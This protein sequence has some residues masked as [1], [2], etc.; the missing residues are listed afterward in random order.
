MDEFGRTKQIIIIR[1]GPSILTKEVDRFIPNTIVKYD[2][3]MINE[4][5]KWISFMD[6]SDNR[7]YCCAINIDGEE[8][9]ELGVDYEDYNS[10]KVLTSYFDDK[11][12]YKNN[13]LYDGGL[14]YAEL[15][16]D[17]AKKDYSALGG[18]PYGQKLRIT[19]NGKSAIASKGDI[20]AGGRYHPKINIHK[21]LAEELGFPINGLDYVQIEFV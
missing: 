9:I 19:Y 20:G 15:S 3:T 21:K 12:G 18:L 2:Q 7:R 4:G 11:E 10:H 13:N 5:R 16:K 1:E 17:P 8:L 6:D 14:Y